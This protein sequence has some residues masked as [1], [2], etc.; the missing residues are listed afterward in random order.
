MQIHHPEKNVVWSY[1]HQYWN[2]EEVCNQRHFS[3]RTFPTIQKIKCYNRLGFLEV[4]IYSANGNKF[5]TFEAACGFDQ[6]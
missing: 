2:E 1:A 5:P 6:S 4:T 3:N